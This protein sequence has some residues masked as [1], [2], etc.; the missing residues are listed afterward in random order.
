MMRGVALAALTVTALTAPAN[1]RR[2]EVHPYVEVAQVLATDFANDDVLTY[3]SLA[4]GIDAAVQSRRIEVQISYRYER[5]IDWDDRDVDQD[6]H[7]G[8]ARAAVAV[9]PGIGIEGGALAARAR[10][11]LRGSATGVTLGNQRNVNQV[12]SAYAGPTVETKAGPVA[13]NAAYRF[14]YTKVED[15]NSPA[16]RGLPRQNTYDDSTMHMAVASAGV[17]AGEVLPVGLTVSGA[18]TRE[19]VSQLDQR[20][21][22][23]YARADAVLPV[24]PTVA[25]VGGIGYED[26]EVS[27]RDAVVDAAGVPVLDSNGRYTTNEASPRRLAYDFDGM[28]WDAG[29]MWRPSRRTTLEVRAGR[30]YGTM[31]YIGSLSWQMSQGSGLQVGVYDSVQS[32]GRGLNK[33]LGSLPTSF[34]TRPDPFS[35]QFDG[36]VFGTTGAAAGSCLTPVLGALTTANFRA[37]G[38][39]G[40]YVLNRGPYRFGIGGGY[41][42]RKFLVPDAA[43]GL[44]LYDVSDELWYAQAFAGRTLDRRSSIDLNAYAN[45][46]DSGQ[47]LIGDS[48]GAGAT[49]SYSYSLGRLGATASLGIYS[50][51][52]QAAETQTSA[53]ALV[54][55]RYSF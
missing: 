12:Y 22:G 24:T 13:V 38:V 23:S 54:G 34:N 9:A 1:A 35:D 36:C 16:E 42:N 39:D 29:V 15:R 17:R 33:A 5:R 3:T 7:S 31:T 8:L 4:A 37:R 18:W 6:V 14:S 20:Y 28:I 27:Q 49:G 43:P 53:Q 32:F 48:F 30:R 47:A 10:T 26:I 44:G 46:Y 11:D 25:V 2:A 21:E 52:P 45:W 41:Q 40:V 51:D 50:V 19:D 55:M